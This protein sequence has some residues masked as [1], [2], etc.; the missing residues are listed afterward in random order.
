[1]WRVTRARCRYWLQS[2]RPVTGVK[3]LAVHLGMPMSVPPHCFVNGASHCAWSR[4]SFWEFEFSET[5]VYAS[6]MGD[7]LQSICVSDRLS[8]RFQWLLQH[9]LCLYL[10]LSSSCSSSIFGTVLLYHCQKHYVLL[11]SAKDGDVD[12]CCVYSCVARHGD[13]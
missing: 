2:L 9:G 12:R 1:M 5:R 8:F 4:N 11:E 13:C 10:F 7:K 3:S 6:P